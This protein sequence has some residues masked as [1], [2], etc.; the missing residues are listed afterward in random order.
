MT[1]NF[2]AFL[3]CL[4]LLGLVTAAHAAP[5]V[6]LTATASSIYAPAN[7][8]LTWTT[9][10]VGAC[11]AGGGWSG[12]KSPTG[13]TETIT[14]VTGTT[15]YGLACTTATG[16]VTVRWTPPT[17]N[18]DGSP[19]T[20]LAGYKI[21]RSN[22]IATVPTGVVVLVNDPTAT[23][24]V[25]TG[26]STGPYHF[27]M[28]AVNAAGVESLMSA[29]VARSVT[30]ATITDAKVVTLEQ[31]PSAP[32]LV[33]VELMVYEVVPNKDGS[34]RLGSRVVGTV[35]LGTECGEALIVASRVKG[36]F[37]SV[38]VN[39]VALKPDVRVKSEVLVARCEL[40]L[41]VG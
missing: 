1:Y 19:L 8:T 35:P 7:V 21:Y 17:T 30:T 27:G 23:S 20:G 29:T 32:V 16:T 40:P 4:L 5:S 34:L 33:T 22:S 37:Y 12:A 39:L 41:S 10:E 14:G 38:P 25:I 15:S 3:A 24:F 31:R 28:K 9:S 36:N 6:T 2:R 11:T 18:V 13:G 26:L